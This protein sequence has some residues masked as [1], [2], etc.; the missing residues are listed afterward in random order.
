A[1]AGNERVRIDISYNPPL[2]DGCSFLTIVISGYPLSTAYLDMILICSYVCGCSLPVSAKIIANGAGNF[3]LIISINIA[4]L[5]V[6]PPYAK[7]TGL[8]LTILL[9]S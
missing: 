6:P 7:I 1:I 4:A 8:S 2:L 9:L 5:L 3:R